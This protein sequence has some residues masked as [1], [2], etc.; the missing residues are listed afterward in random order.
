M[1]TELYSADITS[2][3]R[4][5]MLRIMGANRSKTHVANSVMGRMEWLKQFG[6]V[7]PRQVAFTWCQLQ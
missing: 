6:F 1:D 7:I 4:M 5:A 2:H 3:C